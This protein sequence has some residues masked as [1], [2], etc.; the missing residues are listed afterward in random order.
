MKLFDKILG[1]KEPTFEAEPKPTGPKDILDLTA[2]AGAGQDSYVP[3]TLSISGGVEQ[4][5]QRKV[6]DFEIVD[7]AAMLGDSEYVVKTGDSDGAGSIGYDEQHLPLSPALASWYSS[8]GFIGHQMCSI[9]GQHWLVNKACAMPAEDSLRNGWTTDFKDVTD[10]AQVE[11]LTQRLK[12]IDERMGIDKVMLEA[13]KFCN[14]FGIRILI[15]IVESNDK[16][17]Y[18][19]K[20]NPDGIVPGSFKGWVQIDPQWIYPILSSVGASDP[21]SPTFYEPTFWQA[22]GVMYHHSHLVIL[23]T[24]EV[25]DVLKPSYLF[26]GIP[27]TQRIAERVYAAERTAN[28]APLLAMSKRTTIL[29]VDLAKAKMKMSGFVARIQNW[30]GLRDNYQ[31]KVIGKDEEMSES[32]TSLADLDVVIMTQYQIVAAIARVPAT[33]LLGTSPKGFNATGDHEIKSYHEYLESIQAT[34]FDR[35][36]ERHYLLL[37]LS[38]LDGIE[39]AHTWEPVDTVGA[40]DSATIQ[41]TKADTG[42]ALITA[43]VISPEEERSRIRIDRDSGYTLAEEEEETLDAGGAESTAESAA[44]AE[45]TAAVP[46]GIT[47][48]PAGISDVG[49]DEIAPAVNE[50]LVVGL[51][52]Q[53]AAALQARIDAKATATQS[54]TQTVVSSLTPN[55]EGVKP[56]VIPIPPAH[57]QK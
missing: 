44:E 2:K 33:K 39:I 5:L 25:S 17:Y 20:F 28:E 16:D 37:S 18:K 30:V 52:I 21:S 9:I 51:V 35:F 36:L 48:E 55:V 19:K 38:Y 46:A 13:A 40:M 26:A 15:P 57:L 29:K 43:G 49:D 12:K 53:L 56:S 31:V 27:L 6:E 50:Q 1:R 10:S 4:S 8:Q 41:K 54:P 34:W 22:G 42:V 24:E 11:D 45:E 14:V 3:S 7:E 47:E 32:D 23:R